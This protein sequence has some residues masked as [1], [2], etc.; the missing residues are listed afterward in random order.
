MLAPPPEHIAKPDVCTYVSMYVGIY[1]YIYIYIHIPT[2]IYI[3][4][5]FTFTFR[6]MSSGRTQPLLAVIRR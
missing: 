6:A 3:P 1:I 5:I 2:Y 4:Y